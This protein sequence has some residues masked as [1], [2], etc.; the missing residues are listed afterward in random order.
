VVDHLAGTWSKVLRD[1]RVFVMEGHR[2][3]PTSA[4][5]DAVRGRIA[6]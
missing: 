3:V 2:S 4:V 1:L 6:R 5:L